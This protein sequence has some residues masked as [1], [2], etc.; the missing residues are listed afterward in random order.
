MSG[1][2]G[3]ASEIELATRAIV[4]G[5]AAG[6]R[7]LITTHEGPD[8]DALGSTLA[9]HEALTQRGKDSVMFLAEKELPLPIE[10]RFLPLQEVFHEAPADLSE[11]RGSH[12]R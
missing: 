1:A 2:N 9:L 11:P 12:R 7:F 5:L 4:A 8:G 6:D 3:D 10:Y